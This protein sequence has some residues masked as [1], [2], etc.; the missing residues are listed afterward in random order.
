[1]STKT[2]SAIVSACALLFTSSSLGQST[3]ASEGA[4]PIASLIT[5]IAKRTGKRFVVDPRVRA[6][7]TLIQREAEPLTYAEFLTVL[8]VHGFAAVE[9]NKLVKVVPDAGVRNAAVP[10]VS[11]KRKRLDAEYVTKVIPVRTMPAHM[12]V[13]TLR[14]LLPMQAHLA[15]SICSNDLMIVDTAANVERIEALVQALDRGEPIELERGECAAS[16]AADGDAKKE[17]KEL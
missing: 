12:L 15:A 8:Q 1:M 10:F 17:G 3:A 11:D 7:V 2:F 6:D 4:V 13:P 14:P 9:E 16:H 5:D